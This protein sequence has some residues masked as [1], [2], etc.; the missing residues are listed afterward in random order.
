MGHCEKRHDE[1]FKKQFFLLTDDERL[2]FELKYIDET[3]G[4]LFPNIQLRSESKLA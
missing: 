4:R 2:P 1:F 3:I